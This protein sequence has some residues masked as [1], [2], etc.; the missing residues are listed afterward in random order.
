MKN[1]TYISAGAGSGK[2]Y[3]LTQRLTSLIKDGKVKPEQ[4]ILTTF[5]KKAAAEFKERVKARL[6]EDGLFDEA[7]RLDQALI[8]TVHSVCDQMVNR[9]WFELGLAPGMGVMP[10]EERGSGKDFYISQSLSDLP[11]DEELAFLHE[12]CAQFDVQLREGGIPKGMPDHNF[13]K[14]DLEQIISLSTNYEIDSYE[15]S[16]EKS[17]KFFRQFVDESVTFPDAEECR[18]AMAEHMEF[19]SNQKSSKTNDDRI[20]RLR[21]LQRNLDKPTIKWYADFVALIGE[22]KKRGPQAD[23]FAAKASMVWHA[24]EVYELQERYVRI[25]FT[26]AER[27]RKR[28]EQFKR[29]KSLLD[30]ND[31]EKYMLQLLSIPGIANDIADEFRYLF[32]DEFQDSSP[33]QVKIFDRLSQLM[34]HSYWV[35]D[36]KQSIYG[37]RG[38]DIALIKSVVDRIT[39]REAGCTSETLGTSYRS[40]PKIVDFCNSVFTRTFDGILD[41]ADVVLKTARQSSRGKSLCYFHAGNSTTTPMAV[42]NYVASLIDDGV[43][44]KNIGVLARRNTDLA[45]VAALLGTME[46]ACSRDDIPITESRS[47]LLAGAL[48]RLVKSDC[49]NLAK[50]IVAN[51]TVKNLN[52]KALIEL[53][54]LFDAGEGYTKHD[55]L[56]EVPLIGRLTEIRGTLRQKS[57]AAMVESVVV[58]LNLIDE[59]K[60]IE[61][62][63]MAK[64]CL[65]TL[66]NAGRVYEERCVQM[67]VPSTIEG[68]LAYVDSSNPVGNGNPDGV[69]LHTYHKSKGLQW[70]HVVMMSLNDNVAQEDDIV[71]REVFGVHA[72]HTAQP[73]ADEPY[74]ETYIQL[75]HWPF[76]T[77]KKAPALIRET[78]LGSAGFEAVLQATVEENNRLLY[79]GVTRAADALHLCVSAPTAGKP[80]LCRFRSAG[81]PEI[82]PENPDGSWDPFGI[83]HTFC[84]CTPP[85]PPPAATPSTT[86]ITDETIG[87]LMPCR[88]RLDDV[89]HQQNDPRYVSPST[90]HTK[91]AVLS[92]HDF[93]ERIPLTGNG[94]DM[95][96][97][98]N[99]IH[100]IFAG[101][102]S[103]HI[104]V[105]AT[106]AA[107]GL[108][109]NLTDL[110]AVE[111]AW[112]NLC[113]WLT[114]KYGEAVS[115]HHE[116]PFRL[117]KD[118]QTFVGSIDLVWRTADGDVLVDFKTAPVMKAL[119]L[120]LESNHFAG[121][122]AGQLDAYQ[123][124]LEA[125]G[126]QVI[127]RYIYFPVAGLIAEVGPTL[128]LNVEDV[129]VYVIGVGAIED[130]PAMLHTVVEE[131]SS[132]KDLSRNLVA[133][134]VTD[135][136]QDALEYETAIR[137]LSSQGIVVRY[138]DLPDQPKGIEITIHP[139]CSAADVLYAKTITLYL[140][141]HFPES[142]LAFT[143]DDSTVYML[144]DIDEF[145]NDCNLRVHNN[146]L[147]MVESCI[148]GS[149]TSAWGFNFPFVFPSPDDYPELDLKELTLKAMD[150]FASVQWEFEGIER[151]KSASLVEG[152]EQFSSHLL[153]ND[154]DLFV[155]VSQKISLMNAAGD[156]K[157]VPTDEFVDAVESTDYFEQ[158]DS[159]QFVIRRMPDDAWEELWN[160]L[161][162]LVLDASC[163]RPKPTYI[164]RWNA[165]ISSMTE[166]D[167][168]ENLGAFGEGYIGW[169]IWEWEKAFEGCQFFMVREDGENAGVVFLGDFVSNPYEDDDWAGEEGKRRHY[170]D[171]FCRDAVKPGEPPLLTIAELEAAI[172]DFNWRR[173]H[174]GELL[175][176]AQA[177]ALID[178]IIQ[179]HPDK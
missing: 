23:A 106:V 149:H 24:P 172:P 129:K 28:Y 36:Y 161:E 143:D 137:G 100:Q 12:Y 124:A 126:E 110:G 49:D 111:R 127:G 99:C 33:I 97:V 118:G 139:L 160:R 26:L 145:F 66:I 5:T 21:L 147:C 44:P 25:L 37:F 96:T 175:T 17:L 150:D 6:Y 94:V 98:G 67:N 83:G 10:D 153:H 177:E 113:D 130:V 132:D 123:D 69:Q 121:W 32:V 173:G 57:I 86:S 165:E 47:Y 140:T 93:K 45:S 2:T 52:T 135:S 63:D 125:A 151:A 134:D 46:I 92:H 58:E 61:D 156:L 112:R 9:Y 20:E 155:G 59:A 62:A 79:V 162:G 35:G 105:A 75:L 122:Y 104:D 34:E 164:L 133:N 51:L 41:P 22:M 31:M 40:L 70:P 146:A 76:G 53:K 116:R 38:S 68:F 56:N 108:R 179:K 171:L 115:V 168:R 42:A 87:K 30:Y 82:Q 159:M 11:S 43:E 128:P 178:L 65:L 78:I 88:L 176:D 80:L 1:V 154:C 102:D 14:H 142:Q 48:L 91:G 109:N 8:G 114:E 103:P 16:I 15:R 89:A 27:W 55:F 119:L 39:G 90:I 13:W 131:Y 163:R 107:Y 71:G 117:E 50:A 3:T 60:A 166:D 84:D 141:E 170:V 101:M 64:G 174:S 73:T 167:Y 7:L 19:L 74:P 18:A 157:S 54:L 95:A 148:G 72:A 4:V 144:E 29:E 136:Q 120:D 169:S 152:D 158:V 77:A 85:P 138:I 81:F